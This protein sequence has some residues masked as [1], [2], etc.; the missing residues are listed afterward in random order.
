MYLLKH[1]HNENKTSSKLQSA[2]QGEFKLDDK[3]IKKKG[4][5]NAKVT[6]NV[7]VLGILMTKI[8]C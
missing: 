2:V 1:T 7:N 4:H 5:I 3:K 8:I 6:N